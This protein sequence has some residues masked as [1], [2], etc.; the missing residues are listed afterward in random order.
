MA[1]PDG[2]VIVSHRGRRDL[3]LIGID[4]DGALRWD[5]SVSALSS[6]PP[7]PFTI[8]DRVYVVTAEGDL[9]WIDTRDGT[10]Q[11]I[12]DGGSDTRL[13]GDMWAFVTGEGQ[14]LFDFRGGQIVAIDPDSAAAAALEA[15]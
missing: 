6:A 1:L 4:A 12:F 15:H 5:R 14:V 11:R 10:A 3:R 2:G 8:D 9:L 13:G 7:Q